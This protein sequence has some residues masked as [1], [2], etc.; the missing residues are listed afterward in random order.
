MSEPVPRDIVMEEF[1]KDQ[2]VFESQVQQEAVRQALPAAIVNAAEWLRSEPPAVDPVLDE[3]FDTGDK[4]SLIGASKTRKS[5]YALQLAVCIAAGVDFLGWHIPRRRRVLVV[6]MEIQERHYWRRVRRMVQALGLPPD[7]IGDRLQ[8]V[9]GRGK[10]LS[11]EHLKRYAEETRAEVVIVDPLYKL[12]RGDENSAEHM[13]ALLA[14]FDDLAQSTGAAVIYVHHDA[15][16]SPGDRETRDRGSGSG[17]L[18]R[19]YDACI[20]LTEH[21][22]QEDA[23]VIRV[24]LRNYP[25]QTGF[26]VVWAD[27]CFKVAHDIEAVHATSKNQAERKQRGPNIQELVQRVREEMLTKPWRM[28]QLKAEI[29]GRFGIGRI[30]AEDVCRLLA[31]DDGVE[32][33][34]T[35]TFPIRV[36]VGPPKVTER[37]AKKMTAEWRTREFE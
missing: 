18:G 2:P 23:T 10:G 36:L 28:D 32:V 30:K 24:L 4:V 25:P 33:A 19:D 8:F 31:R 34:K 20:T 14:W 21:R 9:N 17:V 29:Q 7:A 37:E 5:F 1:L 26:T 13:A 22:D 6:Q 3:T 12:N 35:A 16:G 11:V 27:N 15:K